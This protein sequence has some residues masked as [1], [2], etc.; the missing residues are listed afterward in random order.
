MA[1]VELV[2]SKEK[3]KWS[4]GEN[5]LVIKAVKNYLSKYAPVFKIKFVKK[6]N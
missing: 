2:G 3:I 1:S 6:T 4:Q 5:G